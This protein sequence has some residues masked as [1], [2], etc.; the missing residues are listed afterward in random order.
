MK[1]S[2][3]V[4]I[5]ALMLITGSAFAVPAYAANHTPHGHDH[6]GASSGMKTPS[7]M[8]APSDMKSGMG[9]P[10]T[11]QMSGMMN[12]MS[13][14]MKDMSGMMEGGSMTP[15][16][17]KKMSSQMKKMGGMMNNMG[18]MMNQKDMAMTSSVQKKKMEQMRS[19]MDQM[20]KDMPA[21]PGM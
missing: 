15:E 1:Q 4:K 13:S 17:M 16:T 12:D 11:Q 19:Q 2:V 9:E 10:G 6:G 7:N 21:S 3:L 8:G 5:G 20:R 18:G 14:E